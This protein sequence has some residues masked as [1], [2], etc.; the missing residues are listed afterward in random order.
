MMK[1]GGEVWEGEGALLIIGESGG[2]W[3][4]A[5]PIESARV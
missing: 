5:H 3:C 2:F 1:M 4:V